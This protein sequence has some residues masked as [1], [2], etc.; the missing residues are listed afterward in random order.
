MNIQHKIF[1]RK[2][3]FEITSK[4][5]VI[6]INYLNLILIFFPIFLLTGPF[7]PDL[8]IVICSISFSYL[9][10]KYKLYRYFDFLILKVLA[11]FWIFIVFSSLMS[12]NI[13]FSL[14]SSF[15]YLRFLI[16][17]VFVLYIIKNYSN[18]LRYFFYALTIT[19]IIVLFDSY[20]QFFFETSLSGFDKPKLRLTG[21]FG[22]RQIVGSF[23]ARILPL[24]LFLT[25]YLYEKFSLKI[26]F[27]ISLLTILV[28]ISGERTSFFAL[29][30]FIFASYFLFNKNII[31]IFKFSLVYLFLGTII[32]LSNSS[33]KERIINQTL[34]G[35]GI[36]QYLSTDGSKEYFENKPN[37]GFYIFSRAHE[38]HYLT[39]LKMFKDNYF[40]GVG[41]NMFRKKCSDKNFFIEASSC[42]THPHNFLIQLLG[43]TGIIG[44]LFYFF[45]LFL[46]LKKIFIQLYL[47]KI[48]KFDLTTN[49]VGIYLLHI[50]FVINSFLFFLPNG[51]FFNNYLNAIIFIPLGFYLFQTQNDN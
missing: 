6:F 26:L 14:R 23:I 31:N 20:Y 15:L 47:T 24:Y 3:N 19:L 48:K 17:S 2:E 32:I 33:L 34:E 40:L 22:D 36:K 18:F 44:A 46:L 35:F 41:P 10:I 4:F 5:D 30:F 37:R 25:Y 12:D 45:V 16:F 9:C 27:F 51:N 1:E 39:S 13:F 21:P 29:T 49:K 38:V 8:A 43:E 50:G 11:L 7:L 42:T 28:L